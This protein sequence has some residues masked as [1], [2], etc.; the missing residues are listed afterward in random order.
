MPMVQ[1]KEK[2]RV[3]VLKAPFRGAA[4]V[5]GGVGLTVRGVGKGLCWISDKVRMGPSGGEWVAEA[6]LP[7]DARVE[8]VDTSEK[9]EIKIFNEKG[10]KAWKDDDG[11]STTADSIFDEKIA[12]DFC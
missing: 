1:I 5:V 12:K 7:K 6:D 3:K 8:N 10:G 4:A 9:K 2:K 11:A